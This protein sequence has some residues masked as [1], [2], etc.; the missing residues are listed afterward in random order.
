KVQGDSVFRSRPEDILK[1]Q[2]RNNNGKMLPLGTLAAIVDSVGPLKVDRYNLYP[3]ARIMGRPAPGYS[4]GQAL[5]TMEKLA[6]FQLPV[7]IGYEWTA[8]AFQEKK[9]GSQVG[10]IFVLAI[11]V[12]ILILAAQYESWAD[13]L[14]VVLIVPLAVLGAILA[15]II[16]H[17]DNNVYTQVGVVLL[18]GLSAKNAILIVE[19]VRDIRK[20]GADLIE[21]IVQ[22]AKLRFRP[23]LMTSFSFILGVLPLV[24]ASGAGA[25]S[26]Q[27]LGTA[28]F[29][30]MLGVTILGVFFTPVLYLLM[31]RI[32]GWF[33]GSLSKD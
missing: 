29:A 22:G 20:K 30:G 27:A 28:V 23:I 16:R 11:L 25:K 5:E 24:V 9:A 18:V 2:V 12:V 19:F 13:P 31:Q 1:L 10:I 21:A 3:T 14:S 4:S 6:R 33:T 7:G 32:K 15:L 26:R 8:M 17:M